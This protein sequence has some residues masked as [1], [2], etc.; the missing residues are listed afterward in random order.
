[1][2]DFVCRQKKHK[3]TLF[4]TGSMGDKQHTSTTSAAFFGR[5]SAQLED[6]LSAKSSSYD[7]DFSNDQ[8]RS[9]TEKDGGNWFP[10]KP[11]SYTSSPCRLAESDYPEFVSLSEAKQRGTHTSE[12][13]VSKFI[14]AFSVESSNESSNRK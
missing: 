7:Y 2:N 13:G 1:M 3:S 10:Q 4:K 11:N 6:H 9:N 14:N 12:L 5:I 8:P